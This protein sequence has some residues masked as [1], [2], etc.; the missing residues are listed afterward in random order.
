MSG[1]KMLN[2]QNTQLY[3]ALQLYLIVENRQK[4]VLLSIIGWLE[5]V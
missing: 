1:Q 5:E 3:T 2:K 4:F